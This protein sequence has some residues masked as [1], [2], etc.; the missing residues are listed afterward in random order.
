MNYSIIQPPFTLKFR[1]MS[2][3][4]LN[5]YRKWFIE[6]V[7]SRIIEL[8]GA[9]N[10]DNGLEV[11]KPDCSLSSIETL[12]LWLSRQVETRPRKAEEIERIKGRTNFDFSISTRELTN[13]TFS[14]AVDAGMYFGKTL[15]S[16]YRHL[17][18]GQSLDDK[19]FADFG[20][21]ILSGFGRATLNPVRIAVNFCYGVAGDERMAERFAEVYRYW[22]QLAK[23]PG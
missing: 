17:E 7:P 19:K 16:N 22:S 13:R 15:K 5:G 18:W 4:E 3:E 10:S 21:M 12:G 9:I 2:M 14:F 6:V 1:D 20:Q 8:Q 11:W 23:T